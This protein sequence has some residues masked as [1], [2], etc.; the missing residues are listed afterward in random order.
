MFV[1]LKEKNIDFTNLIVQLT[2]H[3]NH[4]EGEHETG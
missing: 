1:A 3:K 4:N 2:H